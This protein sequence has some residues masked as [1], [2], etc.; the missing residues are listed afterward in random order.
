[1]WNQDLES[2]I[3]VKF[4]SINETYEKAARNIESTLAVFKLT[5]ILRGAIKTGEQ[6]AKRNVGNQ[7]Q[8]E[9]II[10]LKY[11]NVKLTLGFQ[12][13]TQEFV[14]YCVTVPGEPDKSKATTEK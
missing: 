4:I 3:H 6:R 14:Q 13:A 11:G 12:H 9:K 5:E 8:F 2:F 10:I 1:M 7:K